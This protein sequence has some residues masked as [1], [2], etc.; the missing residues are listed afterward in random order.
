MFPNAKGKINKGLKFIKKHFRCQK[1]QC[2]F[3][4]SG[5]KTQT[6]EKNKTNSQTFTQ[7]VSFS[8]NNHR[9]LETEGFS[10]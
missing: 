5:M 8:A 3:L 1:E 9:T 7:K 4:S 10:R 6:R 2:G